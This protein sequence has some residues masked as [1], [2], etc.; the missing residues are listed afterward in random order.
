M[1]NQKQSLVKNEGQVY[2]PDYLV[3]N[4]LDF[5]GYKNDSILKKH[6]I[7]NSCGEGA[8]LIEVVSRY[9]TQSLANC[10]D[11]REIKSDLEEYVHG[12]EIEDT[13]FTNLKYK[14]DDAASQ[15]GIKE[16]N[17]DIIHANALSVDKFNNKMD[18]VVGNPPYVRVHN[19]HDNYDMV[20]S[21]SF[22]NGGMTD[23]FLVFYELG[24]RMLNDEGRLCYIAPSSWLSSLA[25]AQ[26][27]SY[28][29][30]KR[31]LKAVIDLGHYQ[32]FNATSYTLIA[33]FENG[34]RHDSFSYYVYNGEKKKEKYVCKLKY[35]DSNILG[36]FYLAKPSKLS[37]LRE[38][39][40]TESNEYATVKN[41]FATLADKI[42]IGDV[43]DVK[44]TIPVIKAS[45]GKWS[46]CLFPYNSDGSPIR[47]D[48]L[49]KD[50]IV[51]N[52]FYKNRKDLQKGKSDNPDWMY[53]GRTQAIK[54]VFVDK[55]AINN[56]IRDKE[57]IKINHVP[58]GSGVY[59]GLYILTKISEQELREI[60]ISDDFIDYIASLKNYKSG[61]YYT[62]NSRDLEQY[63]NYKISHNENI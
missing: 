9:C 52:Y 40:S 15:F 25:G 53:Y 42:F 21:F 45:T 27:R 62:F 55:Y 19:L 63:L 5:A 56:I 7:D 41:G 3:K 50:K 26:M 28:I 47:K 61:G 16:V 44:I 24:I 59:S 38:I 39:K 2:T 8:F 32:P 60:L 12:I 48:L 4:I 49:F 33:L 35:E 54:D 1:N 17:W 36:N 57:S 11:K 20:K 23:L 10:I 13:A 46:K 6:V 18:F 43:P 31:N 14:L 51:K 34:E 29:M 37:E 30:Q 22:A 58:A